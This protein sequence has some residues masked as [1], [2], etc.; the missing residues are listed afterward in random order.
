MSDEN[1]KRKYEYKHFDL[2]Y[3]MHYGEHS[4]YGPHI[5][6]GIG[7]NA[8]H[9]YPY[10]IFIGEDHNAAISLTPA[11]QRVI[12]NLFEIMQRRVTT[13]KKEGP[14]EVTTGEI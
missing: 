12:S 2:G 7:A 13:E 1:R 4:L 5:A 9:L 14:T 11:Q 3:G 10:K 8:V 6:L